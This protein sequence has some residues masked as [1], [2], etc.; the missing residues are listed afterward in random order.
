MYKKCDKNK[1]KQLLKRLAEDGS[2]RIA[3]KIS[4]YLQQALKE[5]YVI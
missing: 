2:V 4:R 1:D 5:K 3:K